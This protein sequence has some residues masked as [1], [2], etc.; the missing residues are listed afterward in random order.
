MPKSY[1]SDIFQKV[2][3]P[4]LYGCDYSSALNLA[5]MIT[6]EAQILLYGF[7]GLQQED[8]LSGGAINARSLREELREHAKVG[9]VRV[10][11]R[12]RVSHDPWKEIIRAVEEEE[13]DLLILS[14]PSL[15][16]GLKIT[17]LQTFT[18]PP[19]DIALLCGDVVH[20]ARR[21]L[22]PIRG[23]PY[24]ELSLR[25]SL[26][27]SRC[28]QAE[29]TCLHLVP[30]I[31]EEGKDAPFRGIHEVLTSLEE[32]RHV[33]IP[34]DHPVDVILDTASEYDLVIMGATAQPESA[35]VSIGEMADQ[36]LCTRP[37]GLMVVKT[38]KPMPKNIERESF[39]QTAISILVD[40]WFAENTYHA[41]EFLDLDRLCEEKARQSLTIS[42][43]LPALNEEETIANVI[44]TLK[45][46]LQDKTPLLDEIVL[47]DSNSTDRTREIAA[48]FGIPVYI[49]QQVLPQYGARLGKGEALWKSLF[50]TRGDIILWIDTDITNINPSFVLGLLGPLLSR[51]NVKFVKG[52]YRRPMKIGKIIQAGGGGRVTELT[53]RPLLNLFY[54]EL[55]G[56]VQ[57]LA[58]EYGGK[59]SALEQLSFY[60]GYGVEIG[61]LIGILEKFGLKAI[62]QVDLLERIHRNQSLE[63]LSKM[64]FAIIQAVIHK[65]EKRFNLG[66]I[67][68]VNKTMKLIRYEPRRLFLEIEEINEKERPP[69]L[70]IPEY[71][72]R[73]GKTAG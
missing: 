63:A 60:S 16:E 35:G 29:V 72:A 33:V 62:A 21:V 70:E 47:M 13:P 52:F 43:A 24:A 32:V 23:G 25:I 9:E 48:E 64:S 56:V 5:R 53:A 11:S 44:Q 15:F 14:W 69:M 45:G 39:G 3:I 38:K 26:A 58:G 22:V 73:Q 17:P 1:I 41:H 46:A 27:A 18:D 7:V 50:V 36:L 59:R 57:P 55:S 8:S 42:L 20:P 30:T 40:K 19:C 6:S 68:E 31:A 10:R 54:P 37:S 61:L 28:S 2:M 71:L 12:V 65:L 66:L 51:P 34:T 67:E 4:A 49:H